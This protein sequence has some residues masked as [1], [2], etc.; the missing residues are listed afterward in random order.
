MRDDERLG[1]SARVLIEEDALWFA[2]GVVGAY[3]WTSVGTLTAAGH[4]VGALAN[5]LVKAVP[6]LRIRIAALP[7]ALRVLRERILDTD[8][9]PR[10]ELIAQ[11]GPVPT[12]G[13][14]VLVS[15]LLDWLPDE[16]AVQALSDAA[17]GL[18]EGGT[19]LM[20]EQVRPEGPDAFEDTDAALHHLRLKC[21]F[22][23]GVRTMRRVDHA[24]GPSGAGRH[25]RPGRGLGPPPVGS[26]QTPVTVVRQA[27]GPH[28]RPCRRGNTERQGRV[29]P[30]RPERPQRRGFSVARRPAVP[31]PSWGRTAHLGP[32]RRGPGSRRSADPSRAAAPW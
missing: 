26:D 9:L 32:T 14:A 19:L 6:E 25:R 22:G 17:A 2:P 13:D 30:E 10:V 8:A 1:G 18:P 15:R 23:S 28:A 12:G 4:G 29:C 7:S 31:E 16:D 27:A 20:V 3:D 11:S 24:G 21:A 5:A